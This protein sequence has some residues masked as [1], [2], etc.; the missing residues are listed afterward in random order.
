MSSSNRDERGK[1]G[2]EAAAGSGHLSAGSGE[3]K[4][5]EAGGG[6]AGGA[7]PGETAGGFAGKAG[8]AEPERAAGD[9]VER[10]AGP[11]AAETTEGGRM[12]EA[13]TGEKAETVEA[14]PGMPAEGSGG[15]AGGA[16]PKRATG[17]E[18]ETVEAAL[19]MPAE[20]SGGRAGGAEPKRAT[21][22]E[23]ET[24]EAAPGMIA[25]SG[26][27][28]ADAVA[29][30]KGLEI[31]GFVA[32]YGGGPVLGPLDLDLP[33]HG[34]YTVL[35]PSGSGKSTLLRAAAGLLPGYAGSMALDGRPLGGGRA[36]GAGSARAM[37]IGLVPQNYGLLP[38]QTAYANVRTALKIARPEEKSAAHGA[39]ARHWLDLVGLAGLE[40]R[41]PRSLSGGQQQRVAIA[42]AFAIRPEL[43]LLDEPFSALD[44]LT[45]ESLQ[46]LLLGS[47]RQQPAAMLF[48]TH[49][50]EEALLLGRKIVILAPAGESSGSGVRIVD[51]EDLFAMSYTDKQSS[52]EF[53]ER[54]QIVRRMIR[55]AW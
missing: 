14:A 10:M 36:G 51:N 5:E 8:E 46:R 48:V 23:A 2:V 32:D 27:G 4:R 33:G 13:H 29:P 41:Y 50:V 16:E 49:D 39:A 45:R 40:S 34:I 55:E 28:G 11:Y 47:W 44:A 18:A 37:R 20:G 21:G 52:A 26:R 25:A 19:G 15:R 22:A 30:G 24:V 9:G 7:E 3:A 17:A 1:D 42:R 43:L 12:A 54:T 53:H 38:W 6:L 35:G 31:R